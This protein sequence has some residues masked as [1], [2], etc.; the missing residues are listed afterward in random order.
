MNQYAMIAVGL[1]VLLPAILYIF[2]AWRVQRGGIAFREFLPLSKFVSGEE[3]GRSTAAAG[4]S[5]ATVILALV[6]LAPALGLGLL[7]TVASYIGSFILLY[8]VAPRIIAA[9]P[10][11]LTIQAFLGE[12]FVSTSVKNIAVIFAFIGFVSLFA[13]ELLVGVT[14]LQPFL[15]DNVYWLSALY[16]AII[17]I[18]SLLGGFK[19]IVAAEQ[20]Q[21]VFVVLAMASLVAFGVSISAA[22]PDPAAL[23]QAGSKMFSGW[24]LPMSFAIGIIF[25]NLPDE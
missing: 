24:A 21:I 1:A 14:V 18:Y 11:N 3:Y 4:V 25:L 10:K 5:L 2:L 9:N 6:N 19:A 17:L 23:T 7:V 8:L 15:G 20:W 13:M 22:S 12:R 16:L